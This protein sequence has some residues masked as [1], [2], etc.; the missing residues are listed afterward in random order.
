MSIQSVTFLI[1]EGWK[2]SLA[3][4][5]LNDHNLIPMKKVDRTYDNKLRYRLVDPS[6]F[7]RFITKKLSNGISLIIG[8]K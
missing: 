7:K 6:K 5:W 3:S 4:R 2:P 1:D 8:F